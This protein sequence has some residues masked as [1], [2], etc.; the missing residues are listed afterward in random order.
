[1]LGAAAAGCWP[2]AG[3]GVPNPAYEGAAADIPPKMLDMV[4]AAWEAPPNKPPPAPKVE[5]VPNRP[6]AAKEKQQINMSANTMAN[7][8]CVTYNKIYMVMQH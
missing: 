5:A 3:A 2:A 1:M 4:G 8:K 7:Y 6:P